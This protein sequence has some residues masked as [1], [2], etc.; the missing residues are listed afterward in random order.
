MSSS[1]SQ[2]LIVVAALAIHRV[3]IASLAFCLAIVLLGG[4]FGLVPALAAAMAEMMD[5][6]DGGRSAYGVAARFIRRVTAFWRRSWP[7]GLIVLG[8]IGLGLAH[9]LMHKVLVSALFVVLGLWG[10]IVAHHAALRLALGLPAWPH[11]LKHLGLEML[12]FG[13]WH[14]AAIA[15]WGVMLIWVLPLATMPVLLL[16]PGILCFA[17]VVL[18]RPAAQ[19]YFGLD[20]AGG[21]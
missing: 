1:H 9:V 18:V 5:S 11:S 8:V 16:G 3:F 19:R 13:W 4:P 2:S 6:L 7:A 12:L 20:E 17:L 21:T 10:L 15:C 14:L